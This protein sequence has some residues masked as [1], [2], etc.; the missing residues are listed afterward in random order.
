VCG[1]SGTSV[2]QYYIGVAGYCAA[3][4]SSQVD[5]TLTANLIPLGS[6][7]FQAPLVNQKVQANKRNLYN[8]CVDSVIDVTAQLKSFTNA[9]QCPTSYAN[10]GVLISRYRANAGHKDLTWKLLGSNNTGSLSLSK[11]LIIPGTYYL[12]VLGNCESECS[13]QRCTCAPC[14]N[15]PVSPYAL[16]VGGVA[17]ALTWS[18]SYNAG[19]CAVPGITGGLYGQCGYLCPYTVSM[20]KNFFDEIP[21]L[22]T[23]FGIAGAVLSAFICIFGCCFFCNYQTYVRGS[24]SVSRHELLEVCRSPTCIMLML[25]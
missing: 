2:C 17:E 13:E 12:N 24:Y 5:F 1:P 18:S 9:C 6:G 22:G 8:F 21:S 11:A 15:L 7:I 10:L 20:R 4:N 3:P 25:S 16:Y 14:T 23:Q 19:S